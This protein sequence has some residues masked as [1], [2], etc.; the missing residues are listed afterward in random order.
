MED[1]GIFDGTVEFSKSQETLLAR[2]YYYNIAVVGGAHSLFERLCHGAIY[3]HAFLI[4]LCTLLLIKI[5]QIGYYLSG[6]KNV[7]KIK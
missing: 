2:S 1:A 7:K 6:D 5:S 4:L 3:L